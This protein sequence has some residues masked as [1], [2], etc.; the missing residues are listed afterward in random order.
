MIDKSYQTLEEIDEAVQGGEI[1]HQKG[2]N[3]I[4][5]LFDGG[6]TLMKIDENGNQVPKISSDSW[7]TTYWGVKELYKA[8]KALGVK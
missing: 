5:R 7:R 2:V 8:N 1:G 6:T 4:T 3:L